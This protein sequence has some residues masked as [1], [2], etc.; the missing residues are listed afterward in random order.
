LKT[1]ELVAHIFRN[2]YGK[3]L[4]IML[5]KFGTYQLEKI[6]DALQEALLKAMQVWAYKSVPGNPSAWLLKVAGN[7]MIDVLRKENRTRIYEDNLSFLEETQM[8][9]ENIV[10]QNS[11]NDNQLKMIFACCHPSL[12][13]EYQIILSL[14][15]I[16]GFGNREIAKALLKKEETIAKSFTRAKKKFKEEVKSLEIPIEIGLKSRLNVVL[17]II[18]LLFTEGYKTT[19]GE[20]LIK[21]DICF[22][23][24]RLSLVLLENKYCKQSDV[25][26]LIALMCFHAARFEARVDE[27]NEI[28]DLEHQDRS[29]YVEE[30]IEIGD[31]HLGIATKMEGVPSDYHFQ[32]A[33]AYHHCSV[34]SFEKTNWKAILEY[35]DLQ[36]KQQY[37]P[38]VELNRVVPFSRVY[39]KEKA[40]KE[41]S[42][43]EDKSF[44][45][46]S[47]MYYAIK[48]SLYEEVNQ[49]AIMNDFL[50]KA[51]AMTSNVLEKKH[52]KKKLI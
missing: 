44:F 29:K 36:L 40:L 25:Y 16:G 21:K 10:L 51:I 2:E 7:Q 6:E 9:P 15:L 37:S 1:E 18:Y 27:K 48:A 23:A 42:I 31:W 32:A 34:S 14:K 20:I 38:A 46:E 19:S 4:A 50:E 13:Q 8:A 47:S 12:S 33:I 43:L 3:L 49:N 30:L 45:K 5:N 24:I 52:L 39:S 17:K 22:E 41:L 35:Y 26:A 11:I 28:V